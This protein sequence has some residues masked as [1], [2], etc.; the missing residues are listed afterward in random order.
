MT[1][2]APQGEDRPDFLNVSPTWTTL[3]REQSGVLTGEGAA[4]AAA[5]ATAEEVPRARPRPRRLVPPVQAE[6]ADGQVIER[7]P[8]PN[9]AFA[10]GGGGSSSSSSSSSERFT[11]RP[12]PWEAEVRMGFERKVYGLLAVQL[13]LTV[14]IAVPIGSLGEE[15]ANN[16]DWLSC[17]LSVLVWACTGAVVRGSSLARS[18]PGNYI[19]LFA[20]TVCT[21]VMVGV[22][23]AVASWER[24]MLSA[25]MLSLVV[26]GLSIYSRS[27]ESDF[28]GFRPLLMAVGFCACSFCGFSGLPERVMMVV[29]DFVGVLLFCAFLVYDTQAMLGGTRKDELDVDEYVF[30]ALNMYADIVDTFL[31]L[32]D[33]LG[34]CHPFIRARIRARWVCWAAATTATA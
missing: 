32:L 8:G 26:L 31:L 34:G 21:G 23:T 11:P 1:Q 17:L 30:A 27:T 19:L 33:M 13:L 7:E 3:P 29:Y 24:D 6:P 25:G 2:L 14:A 9:P 28:T 5:A 15:W 12:R 16:N 10:T 18:Y 20:S 22:A 4:A